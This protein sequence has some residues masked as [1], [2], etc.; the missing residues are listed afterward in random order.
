MQV[1]NVKAKDPELKASRDSTC[2]LVLDRFQVRLPGTRLL[3]FIDNVDFPAA[4]NNSRRSWR[5][6]VTALCGFPAPVFQKKYF[7]LS[8]GTASSFLETTS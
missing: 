6:F 4:L 2:N 8:F 5:Q 1:L 3:C 7:G